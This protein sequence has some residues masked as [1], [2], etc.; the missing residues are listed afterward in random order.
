MNMKNVS[1]DLDLQQELYIYTL[2]IF[3]KVIHGLQEE[4]HIHTRYTFAKVSH[5][6]SLY[7][8]W[9]QHLDAH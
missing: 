2:Y 1:I 9:N 5:G 7:C 4:L 8:L 3:A 6:L